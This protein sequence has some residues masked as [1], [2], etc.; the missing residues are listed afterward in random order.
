MRVGP[1]HSLGAGRGLTVDVEIDEALTV[2]VSDL[3]DWVSRMEHWS[4]AYRQ[5]GDYGRVNNVEARLQLGAPGHSCSIAFRL[6]QL[7]AIQ[8][9]GQELWLTLEQRGG[10]AT[11]V[12]LTPSGLDV[13][14]CHVDGAPIRGT[15][16]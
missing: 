2:L 6:D 16:A 11:A 12:H 15:P 4:L 8:T 1:R 9:Y 3:E 14:L 10:V 13:D 5:G 7:D